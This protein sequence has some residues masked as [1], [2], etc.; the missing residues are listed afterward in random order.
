MAF[1]RTCC[2]LETVLSLPRRHE[3]QPPIPVQPGAPPSLVTARG[4]RP[5]R[6]RQTKLTSAAGGVPFC[7]PYTHR[8][9]S[10]SPQPFKVAVSTT[11]LQRRKLRRGSN[12]SKVPQLVELGAEPPFRA[13]T[14]SLPEEGRVSRSTSEGCSLREPHPTELR[15]VWCSEKRQELG[16]LPPPQ[17]SIPAPPFSSCVALGR[18]LPSLSLSCCSVKW[19]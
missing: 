2:A 10:W 6:R 1:C 5:R 7:T 13:R 12:L 9:G 4:V 11:V 15:A 8:L 16:S 18:D 3:G 19:G 17:V 14:R